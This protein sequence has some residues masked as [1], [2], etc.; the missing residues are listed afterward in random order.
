LT[1]VGSSRLI[2]TQATPSLAGFALTGLSYPVTLFGGQSVSCNI[3]F[4]PQSAVASSGSVVIEF[5]NRRDTAAYTMTIPVSGIGVTVGTLG[6]TPASLSFG[7]VTLG[8]NQSLSETVTNTG[9][10]SL[11][12][13]QVA[14]SGSGFSLSGITAPVTLTT[15]EA[16]SFTVTL[17]PA[18]AATLTGNV[19]ITSTASNPTLT[20]PL[21]G[22]GT[23]AA[24][25]L[26]V[27]PTTLSLGS[28]VA[29]TTGTASGS[30][31][32]SGANVTVT[33]ASSNNSVFSVSGLSLP[34]TIPAGQSAS[35]TVTF[36][37]QIAG[38]ATGVLSFTSNAQPSTTA[39]TLTATGTAA[40]T[41]SVNLSWSASTSSG[42]SGYNIYRAVYVNSCGSF[43]KINSLLNTGTLYTD[44]VVVD[45]TSYCYATTAVNSSDEESGYSDIISNVQIP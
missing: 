26:S 44:I 4:Q 30:L 13:S 32:A 29:E 36:G 33:G 41:H 45:G 9:G 6:S 38:A 2:I 8:S 39:E 42:I 25:Q 40:P 11:T 19:T 3:T 27:T 31:T 12:I 7:R 20:I 5:H 37:P 43:S 18:S 15:G 1:N 14:I 23:A 28:V 22:I 17:T 35:F 34:A 21:S 24:G 16:M 10:S